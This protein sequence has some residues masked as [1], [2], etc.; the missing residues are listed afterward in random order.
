MEHMFVDV[1][2]RIVKGQS[3]Q[4]VRCQRCGLLTRKDYL[5]QCL[6]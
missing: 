1:G 5:A 3:V 4:Y 2:I 6:S